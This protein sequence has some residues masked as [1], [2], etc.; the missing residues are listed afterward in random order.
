[1]TAAALI[2]LLAACAAEPE[3]EP[4][5][6]ASAAAADPTTPATVSDPDAPVSVETVIRAFTETA[7]EEYQLRPW[8][9]I[10]ANSHLVVAGEVLQVGPGQVIGSSPDDPFAEHFAAAE[11]RVTHV[12]RSIRPRLDGEPRRD[13]RV[14]TGDVVWVEFNI[15]ADAI[16]DGL[17]AGMK[18]GL[19]LADVAW[20]LS[21]SSVD[22]SQG[23]I[24]ED[25]QVWAPI[26][27]RGV[28]IEPVAG[29]GY[30]VPHDATVFPSR[31][32]EKFLD[33]IVPAPPPDP[34]LIDPRGI[35]RGPFYGV[36]CL[37]VGL[38][39]ADC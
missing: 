12:S 5:P 1:V 19:I 27:Q 8:R 6:T 21:G 11:V 23:I 14:K 16:D 4:G 22:N 3:G 39:G 36:G 29:Q 7:N 38:A 2:V 28:F 24:P 37:H 13:Q 15:D 25:A 35:T 9:A 31:T 20:S 33:A 32:M 18:V 26:E 34:A 10:A 30:V 17:R